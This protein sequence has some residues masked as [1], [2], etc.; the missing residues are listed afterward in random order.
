[1]RRLLLYLVLALAAC[2]PTVIATKALTPTN[3]QPTASP[4]SSATM[5]AV[6]GALGNQL[7]AAA[8]G[9]SEAQVIAKLGRPSRETITHGIGSPRWEYDS[10]YV[11]GFSAGT[12]RRVW[13]ILVQPPAVAATVEG[14]ALRDTDDAFRSV[15][16][17]FHVQEFL[18]SGNLQLQVATSD[19]TLVAGFAVD[20]SSRFVV[21]NTRP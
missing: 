11:I 6:G 7:G 4:Q 2:A 5:P 18:L 3:S 9:D 14:F 15:Y 1:M 8:L 17:A 10:G 21:I 12:D 19:E 16:A 13:L 20:H